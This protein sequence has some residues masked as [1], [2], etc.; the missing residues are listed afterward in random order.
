MYRIIIVDDEEIILDGIKEIFPWSENG[1]EVVGGF[2][3]AKDALKFVE[4][5]KVDVIFTDISMPETS[6]LELAN[7]L[8]AYPDTL[9][10]IFSS[11]ANYH[12]MREALHLNIFDYLRKPLSYADVS[13]CLERINAA[14]KKKYPVKEEKE[15]TYYDK[16]LNKID[17]YLVKNYQNAKLIEAAEY[18][19]MSAN[20]L[21]KI[22]KEKR[23][24]GFLDRLNQIRMA[25]AAEMLLDPEYKGYEIA[26][27]VGY[28]N[29]KN[30]AR[31]FK[32]FHHVTPREYKNGMRGES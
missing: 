21:S 17:E 18:V 22:Y 25:K 19:G 28:E 31:A 14:F 26:Y 27:H 24:I 1:F 3:N 9:V 2:N 11:Y 12:Y 20:Y 7:Q 30:F 23:G 10:V 8:K 29:P 13:A 32:A 4:K 6:G 5:E 15:P 16:I